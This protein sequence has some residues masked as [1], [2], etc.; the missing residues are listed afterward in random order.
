LQEAFSAAACV[1]SNFSLLWSID[2]VAAAAAAAAE[3]AEAAMQLSCTLFDHSKQLFV[4]LVA[5]RLGSNHSTAGSWRFDSRDSEQACPQHRAYPVPGILAILSLPSCIALGLLSHNLHRLIKTQKEM[6]CWCVLTWS[7]AACTLR[8]C[9]PACWHSCWLMQGAT[10]RVTSAKQ[11][12]Q[13]LLTLVMSS[14][15]LL[16]QQVRLVQAYCVGFK[17]NN[18]VCSLPVAPC[19]FARHCLV[20]AGCAGFLDAASAA[21]PLAVACAYALSL[22]G[23]LAGLETVRLIRE[24]V[25]AALAYGL[26]LTEEQVGAA[27]AA[28]G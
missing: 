25:A 28:A 12:S 17:L 14:E 26:D 10:Q 1:T 27:A 2:P 5:L 13:Y 8:R 7:Q 24:P 22:A 15:R 18:T 11:S 3:E 4:C 20:C 23:K 6:Q 19:K 21:A 9:Q 16:W